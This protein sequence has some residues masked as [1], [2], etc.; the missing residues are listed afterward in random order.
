MVS[1]SL[2][3]SAP[4]DGRTITEW[5]RASRS[6]LR[7]AH[8]PYENAVGTAGA[9]PATSAA[10]CAARPI[11]LSWSAASMVSRTLRMLIGSRP[12]AARSDPGR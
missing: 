6:P 2:V 3:A 1:C 11:V 5:P 9:P 8:F 10:T 4:R 7:I 12:S